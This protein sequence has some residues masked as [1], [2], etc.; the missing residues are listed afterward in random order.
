MIQIYFGV[1]IGV[2]EFI[3]LILYRGRSGVIVA[4]PSQS[5]SMCL[6]LLV[7]GE[8]VVKMVDASCSMSLVS[9]L[10]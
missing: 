10:L 3:S 1:F 5:R 2:D 8:T 9:V 4:S 6:H 7:E